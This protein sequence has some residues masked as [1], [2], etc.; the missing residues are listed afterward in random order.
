MG[1]RLCLRL[2]Q[3]GGDDDLP[4]SVRNRVDELGFLII[5]GAKLNPKFWFEMSMWDGHQE[6]SDS[7]KRK[8]YANLGQ[9]F[10]PSAMV[11]GPIG[12]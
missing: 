9:T 6:G 11:D 3:L 10:S 1:W 2:Y 4:S 5:R 7:D 12:E 8:T